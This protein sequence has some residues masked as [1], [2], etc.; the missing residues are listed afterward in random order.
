MKPLDC[1][2]CT[3]AAVTLRPRLVTRTLHVLACAHKFL[4][5]CDYVMDCQYMGFNKVRQQV[6]SP[7]LTTNLVTVVAISTRPCGVDW[8]DDE[9]ATRLVVV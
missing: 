8:S 5:G 6:R 7:I 3:A 9:L 2:L 1:E 4:R